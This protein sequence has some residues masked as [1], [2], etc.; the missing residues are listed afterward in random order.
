[1]QQ[2]TKLSTPGQASGLVVSQQNLRSLLMA[3]E[4]T[5]SLQAIAHR[6]MSIE[7]IREQAILCLANNPDLAK[8]SSISFISALRHVAQTGLPFAGPESQAH[9]VPFG[10]RVQVLV[11]YRGLCSLSRRSGQV[12]GIWA[13]AVFEKDIF[14]VHYG[15]NER[16]V[17]EPCLNSNRG[18][19]VAAYA[20]ARLRAGT[21]QFEVMTIDEIE[22][23]RQKSRMPHGEPWKAHYPE[24]CKKTVIRRLCKYLPCA[25]DI[26]AAA[27][28]EDD[29]QPAKRIES[30]AVP[31][32]EI[33]RSTGEIRET[34]QAIQTISDSKPSALAKN[35]EQKRQ[36]LLLAIH[37]V[38]TRLYPGYDPKSEAEKL[39]RLK[40]VYGQTVLAEIGKMPIEVIEAGLASLRLQASASEIDTECPECP[41]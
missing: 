23:I 19:I 41:V 20:I 28:F 4:L 9:L 29:D 1:M 32:G 21:L 27:Q 2:Q 37:D 10:Q 15:S 33:D 39:K 12:V 40:F 8:C 30:S 18:Q 6:C 22:S 17:H 25:S 16:I 5:E 13:H 3:K 7:S 31:E 26:D 38:L 34:D 11:D 35:L 36:D 24:M 14:E